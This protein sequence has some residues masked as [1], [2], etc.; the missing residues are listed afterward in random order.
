MFVHHNSWFADVRRLFFLDFVQPVDLSLNMSEHGTCH[1]IQVI[2]KREEPKTWNNCI[3]LGAWS[4]WWRILQF[5]TWMEF[6]LTQAAFRNPELVGQQLRTSW[7]ACT[8]G[9]CYLMYSPGLKTWQSSVRPTLMLTLPELVAALA[10]L[11][12]LLSSFA[13]ILRNIL[14]RISLSVLCNGSS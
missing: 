8:E 7:A 6:S 2:L 4:V 9:F 12:M 1:M 14:Q 13:V 11:Q 10:D 3:T 5:Q